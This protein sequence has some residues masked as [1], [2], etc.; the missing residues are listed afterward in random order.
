MRNKVSPSPADRYQPTTQEKNDSSPPHF[1]S[2]PVETSRVYMRRLALQHRHLAIAR[3]QNDLHIKKKKREAR[4]VTPEERK[5]RMER[6]KDSDKLQ[7]DKITTAQDTI[8]NVCV[9]LSEDLG[10]T[11]QY[12]QRF[13]MQL[14][15]IATSER[16][17]SRW[18]AYLSLSLEEVNAGKSTITFRYTQ[19]KFTS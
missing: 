8:W 13:L 6:K 18:N 16:K 17:T 10:K 7:N 2:M 14:L 1:D 12:W 9:G 4:K 5:N 3:A 15:R 19:L 11:P